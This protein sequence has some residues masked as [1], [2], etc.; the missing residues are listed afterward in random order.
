MK[1]DFEEVLLFC[2]Q[3]T[4]S[5]YYVLISIYIYFLQVQAVK[6][7]DHT[8]QEGEGDSPSNTKANLQ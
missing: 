1:Q 8:L 7:P 6:P 5:D 3:T 2:Y 4:A